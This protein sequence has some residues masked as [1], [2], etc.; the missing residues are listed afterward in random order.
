MR[1]SIKTLGCRLNQAESNKIAEKLASFGVELAFS[2][3]SEPDLCIINTCC[4][5]EKAVTKSRL[6]INKIRNR[7]K[8][9]K[10]LLCGCAQE[11]KSE[12][13]F[14]VEEKDKISEF[15]YD[16]FLKN[17]KIVR[18]DTNKLFKRGRTRAFLKIQ[19]GCNNFCSYCIIPY[20]RKKMLSVPFF[21]VLEE[22]RKKEEL[23]FKE[24]ILT[25]VNIGKYKNK[26]LDLTG[27][28][29][30]ILKETSISRI[31]FGSINPDSVDDK[32][33]S[34]FQNERVCPHLHL[35]LQSGSDSILKRMNRNYKTRDYLNIVRKI[36]RKYSDFNFTTDVIVGFPGETREEFEETCNFVKKVGFSKVHIFKYSR[37]EGT[38]A[39]KMDKQLNVN[40]KKERALKLRLID[41]DLEARFSEKMI[42]QR[43]EILFENKRK[44]YFSGFTKNYFKVRLRSRENLKNKIKTLKISNNHLTI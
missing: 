43:K 18:Q 28:V 37:R 40:I 38:V 8:S 6:E 19:D 7:H 35:S 17:N 22:I 32:F 36:R 13:D 14:F 42:G 11:L 29:K 39:D 4:I 20:V 2:A 16:S 41:K 25:G 5:T 10:V 30:K 24:I 3:K 31:R 33:I 34:L 9:A 23:G 15:I 27:L 44:E 12:A 21:Q 1:I 26:D